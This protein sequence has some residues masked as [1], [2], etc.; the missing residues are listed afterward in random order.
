METNDREKLKFILKLGIKHS[1]EHKLDLEK[2]AEK[3]DA[4][5]KIIIENIKLAAKSLESMTNI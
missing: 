3:M 2:W 4:T 5:D 1:K